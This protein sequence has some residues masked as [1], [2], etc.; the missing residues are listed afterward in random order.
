[1]VEDVEA[2]QE[3]QC[4]FIEPSHLLRH[5][6]ITTGEG[7]RTQPLQGGDGASALLRSTASDD[8]TCP[9]F[10]ETSRRRQPQTAGAAYDQT[11]LPVEL[12]SHANEERRMRNEERKKPSAPGCG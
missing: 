6:R 5:R 1:M 3:R 10:Q 8:N 4:L 9:L 12:T 7:N 11:P 2:V